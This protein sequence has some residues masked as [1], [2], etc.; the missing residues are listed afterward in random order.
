MSLRRIKKAKKA[1][2]HC[3]CALLLLVFGHLSLA[4]QSADRVKW[5]DPQH[6]HS[7]WNT[8]RSDFRQELAPDDP[9]KT[10]FVLPYKYKFIYR[11][12]LLHKTALVILKNSE[13][14]DTR[15]PGY[16]SAFS[17]DIDSHEKNQIVGAEAFSE[18]KF[19]RLV[20]FGPQLPEDIFFSYLTCSECEPSKVL[21]SFRYDA[22]G[23]AWKLRPWATENS[24]WWTSESGP[25]VWFDIYGGD[26]TVSFDC[27]YGT[28]KTDHHDDFGVRCKEVHEPEKG[29]FST[30]D[31]T[32][33]F[34]FSGAEPKLTLIQGREERDL[35]L[36]E[37]CK[38]SPSNKLCKR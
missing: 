5:I 15:F 22:V 20:K 10:R 34:S 19:I 3:T 9:A 24:I 32:I 37:L 14:R 38:Q 30:T 6:S 4:A 7:V 25:T 17:Y 12:A 28:L 33:R 27:L 16:Y 2:V 18:W 11:V 1:V 8:I 31:T 35:L 36:F 29:K 13:A 26:D 21:S 23:R